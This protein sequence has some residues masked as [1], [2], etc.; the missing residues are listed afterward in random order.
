MILS[1]IEDVIGPI[2]GIPPW[3]GP[4]VTG[5]PDVPQPPQYETQS[6]EVH[7]TLFR[8]QGLSDALINTLNQ[9]REST[10]NLIYSKVR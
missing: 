1:T 2:L 5:Q 9:S 10:S 6:M 7:G 3:A 4:G 8:P